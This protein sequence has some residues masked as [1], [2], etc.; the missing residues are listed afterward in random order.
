M[1]RKD[2]MGRTGMRAGLADSIPDYFS[3]VM[4]RLE[5]PRSRISKI[6]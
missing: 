2:C 4:Q 3:V 1:S 6:Y 5:L